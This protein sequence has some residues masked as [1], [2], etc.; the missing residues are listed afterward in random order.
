MSVVRAQFQQYMEILYILWGYCE[1]RD[2]MFFLKNSEPRVKNV[3]I[4]WGTPNFFSESWKIS[5]QVNKFLRKK[6]AILNVSAKFT[7]TSLKIVEIK[8]ELLCFK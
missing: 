6:E 5:I 7:S 8:F 2:H 1:L 3:Q 4:Q